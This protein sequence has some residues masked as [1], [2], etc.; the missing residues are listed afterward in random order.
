MSTIK[1]R[2]QCPSAVV[3]YFAPEMN[4]KLDSAV[5]RDA[6]DLIEVPYLHLPGERKKNHRRSVSL[7]YWVLSHYKREVLMCELAY[8]AFHIIVNTLDGVSL[9]VISGFGGLV[10][11][12]LASGTQD[13]RFAHG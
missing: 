4:N 9:C 3:G 10:V 11:S 12:M 7:S 5:V 6:S 13:C 1:R 2:L 8:S